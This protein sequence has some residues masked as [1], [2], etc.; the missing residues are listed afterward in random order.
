MYGDNGVV[1]DIDSIEGAVREADVVVVGFEFW[2]ERLL[3]D[4][5]PDRR[6]GTPPIIEVVEPLAGVQE[7]TIW[8][9]ARRP[10]ITPPE[11]FLFFTWPHSIAFLGQSPLPSGV[12][13]RIQRDQGID[14]SEEIADVLAEL[15][16]IEREETLA[17]L[18]GGEGYETVWSTSAR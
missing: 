17:A 1:I 16:E 10:G 11:Q 14:V 7:R 8:L 12:T 18:R 3:V 13:R 5:R 15:A 6:H 4:L 2:P 9:N